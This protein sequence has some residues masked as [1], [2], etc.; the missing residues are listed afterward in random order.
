MLTFFNIKLKVMKRTAS[1]FT[2]LLFIVSCKKSDTPNDNSFPDELSDT[3][4]QAIEAAGIDSTSTYQMALFPGGSN[5]S[6]W[7]KKNDPDYVYIFSRR[8]NPASDNKLLFINAMTH[9]GFLLTTKSNY[10]FQNQNGLAYVYNS[11]SIQN[12]STYQGATCQQPLYGLDCSGMIY[13][14][15]NSSGLSL[16]KGATTDYV[17]TDLWNNSFKNSS[18]FQELEMRDTGTLSASLIEAGDFIV[19]PGNHI[20]MVFNNGSSLGVFNSLGRTKYPCSK[21]SDIYHGPV[22]SKDLSKWVQATFGTTYHVLRV[23]QKGT[24]GLTT[25]AVSSI[26]G[27]SAVLGGIITNDGGTAITA[28]GVCWSTSQNPTIANNKTLEGSGS[29]NFTSNVTGLTANTTYYVRAYATNNA[30]TAYGNEVSFIANISNTTSCPFTFIWGL[31]PAN[32]YPENFICSGCTDYNILSCGT[33]G[34]CAINDDYTP[35]AGPVSSLQIGMNFY[36]KKDTTIT[37]SHSWIYRT[38]SSTK[39]DTITM[40]KTFT[41]H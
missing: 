10:T 16:P 38:C 21:N 23:I 34:V 14:M 28:R 1:I 24:P 13:Q 11:K 33:S 15:A 40:S 18:D 20:G 35:C 22:I 27:T 26:T 4:I 12:A 41:C 19:A 3:Q 6:Q 2:I 31:P 5:M 32:V 30:G 9:A 36:L 25:T 39:L 7:E 8:T 29:G 37:I 17:K